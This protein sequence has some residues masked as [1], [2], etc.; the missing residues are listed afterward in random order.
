M[1][2][3]KR[4]I[5]DLFNGNRTIFIPFFQRSYVW[6]EEQWERFLAD[7]EMVSEEKRTYFLGSVILKQMQNNGSGN[8]ALPHLIFS[9]RYCI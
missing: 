2:A 9:L 3:G 6:K 1:D 4:L 7:M 5:N 8:N